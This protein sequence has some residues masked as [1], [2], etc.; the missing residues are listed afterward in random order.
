MKILICT[1]AL[2]LAAPVAAQ[3]TPAPDTGQ[4]Q[5][6][7]KGDEHKKGCKCCEDIKQHEG[8]MDCCDEHAEGHADHGGQPAQ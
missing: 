3:A 8:K 4:G 2:I 7:H 5:H 1:F 6:Q